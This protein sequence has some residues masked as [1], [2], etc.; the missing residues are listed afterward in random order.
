MRLSDQEKLALAQ[1]FYKAAGELVSTKN[2]DG[3]R[4]AVDEKY[5]QMYMDTGAKSFDV[6]LNGS[7][8]GTYSIK[9]KKAESGARLSVEDQ[10]ALLEWAIEN[11]CATVDMK[12]VEQLFAETGEVPDG[13]RVL[14]YERPERVD[15]TTLRIETEKV[16]EAL[17]ARLPEAMQQLLLPEGGQDA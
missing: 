10:P 17:G 1:A 13:C 2:P 4:A 15:G 14:T 9:V 11:G 7:K 12:K 8:V 6:K 5:V 16:A 3:L